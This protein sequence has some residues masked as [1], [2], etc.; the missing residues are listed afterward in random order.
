MNNVKALMRIKNEIQKS[1]GIPREDFNELV[2]RIDRII[3]DILMKY[4]SF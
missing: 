3:Q 1:D 2:C 4:D